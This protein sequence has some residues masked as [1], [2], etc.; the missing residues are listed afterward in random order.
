M[1]VETWI[2]TLT[3]LASWR[4]LD[5]LQLAFVNDAVVMEDCRGFYLNG[6]SW[7]NNGVGM[8]EISSNAELYSGSSQLSRPRIP[9]QS[10]IKNP[11]TNLSRNE[12]GP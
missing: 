9:P 1:S 5:M 6:Y 4:L 2:R 11:Q 8:R 12:R 10:I 7:I 3:E